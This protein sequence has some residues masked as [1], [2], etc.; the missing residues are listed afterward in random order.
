MCHKVNEFSRDAMLHYI[1]LLINFNINYFYTIY[2]PNFGITATSANVTGSIKPQLT[3][4]IDVLDGK[5]TKELGFE[6]V[7]TL[8]NNISIGSKT[9]C[10][11]KTQ[12]RLRTSLNGNL[13]FL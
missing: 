1:V 5:F 12:P 2:K 13:G 8:N 10:L 11:E 9:T 4:G 6:I 3:F 7:G